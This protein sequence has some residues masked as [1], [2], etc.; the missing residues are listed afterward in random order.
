MKFKDLKE[1]LSCTDIFEISVNSRVHVCDYESIDDEAEAY[2][3]D[4][5]NVIYIR[6][7]DENSIYIRL[8]DDKRS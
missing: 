7:Y 6:A 3:L 5:K 1:I 4:E 2:G 8:K